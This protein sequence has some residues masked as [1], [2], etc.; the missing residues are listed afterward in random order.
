MRREGIS[1][2]MF[3]L[4]ERGI[5]RRPEIAREVRG[6]VAIRFEE[7]IPPIR[8]AF[9]PAVVLVEDGDCRH[10]DLVISG[11]LADI[12]HLAASPLRGGVP[13]PISRRGRRAIANVAR[14]RVRLT[15][16]Q[17]LARGV[18]SVLAIETERVRR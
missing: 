9:G 6:R 14:G 16:D 1:P 17:R 7:E 2:S 15:G 11:R 12:I 5:E 13:D 3:A 18:L 4:L 10:P 8:V